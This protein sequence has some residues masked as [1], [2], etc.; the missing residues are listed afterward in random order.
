M[1]A[2]DD[3]LGATRASLSLSGARTWTVAIS[4]G[5]RLDIAQSLVFGRAPV[6]PASAPSAVAVPVVDPRKSLSKTHGLL[7][8][9][10]ALLWVT[11][12]HSTNG[13]TVTN[14]VGEATSC[15]PGVAM[16]V[17]EGWTISF[18]EVSLIAR[19]AG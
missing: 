9:R 13:T 5:R 15:P 14:A 16:P 17:G 18:G 12:L 6:A 7:E 4:D 10:D 11:D 2:E 8:V 3:D 19:L 1:F